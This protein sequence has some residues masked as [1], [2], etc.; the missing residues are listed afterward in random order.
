MK[1]TNIQLPTKEIIAVIIITI[2]IAVY[3]FTS[4]IFNN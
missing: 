2:A 1:T 3:F 4:P